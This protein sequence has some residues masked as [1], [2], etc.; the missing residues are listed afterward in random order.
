MQKAYTKQMGDV[1]KD[2][3]TKMRS[4]K[5]GKQVYCVVAHKLYNT[6]KNQQVQY[7]Q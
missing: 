3:K 4:A 6:Y 7:T 5:K 2:S 1:N